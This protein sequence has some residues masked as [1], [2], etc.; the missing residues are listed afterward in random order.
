[1]PL[2][3]KL[4]CR[5]AKPL[6]KGIG[7]LLLFLLRKMLWKALKVAGK[8]I[9]KLFMKNKKYQISSC[10]CVTKFFSTP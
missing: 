3:L 9:G 10:I 8:Q 7:L 1:M 2:L 5:I 6:L 4:L